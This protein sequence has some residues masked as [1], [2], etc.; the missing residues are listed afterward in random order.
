MTPEEIRLRM[1]GTNGLRARAKAE[2]WTEEKAEEEIAKALEI[3][4]TLVVRAKQLG[5]KSPELSCAVKLG[6][7]NMDQAELILELS[8]D[9]MFDQMYREALGI[10]PPRDE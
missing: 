7:L 8:R 3:D 1:N 5:S 2:G 10:M 9:P 6:M 4:V